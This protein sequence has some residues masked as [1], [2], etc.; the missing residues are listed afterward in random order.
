MMR[1][2]RV[3][4]IVAAMLLLA[5]PVL[6]GKF[7]LHP[8]G[9]GRHSYAS[10]KAQ[11]GLDDPSSNKG[12]PQQALYFQK[13]TAT[14]DF[15]AGVAVFKGF[16]GLTVNQITGLEWKHREDGWCGAGAPRWNIVSEDANGERYI[17]FL[18]CAAAVHTAGGTSNN[19]SGTWDWIR[20]EQPAPGSQ[21]CRLLGPPFT[22]QPPGTCAGFTVTQLAIVFDEGTTLA[23][24]PYGSGFVYLDDITVE[25]D[26]TPH[27]W[28]SASD[29]SNSNTTAST[30]PFGPSVAY[31]QDLVSPTEILSDLLVL[32]PTVPVT[33]FILYP[34]VI[35]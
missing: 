27:V 34:D 13:M 10:W 24:L 22:P 14:E 18:G 5:L 19:K 20:D 25:V 16:A 23:G 31:A 33:S 12:L 32:F 26:S 11:E 9:F 2:L 17:T 28:H 15:A 21:D 35:P 4:G 30:S 29:N 8:A 6:A 7:T 1:K 3:I